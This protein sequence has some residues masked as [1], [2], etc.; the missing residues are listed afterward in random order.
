MPEDML[1]FDDGTRE[2]SFIPSYFEAAPAGVLVVS[3]EPGIK[4][5]A[6]IGEG[7]KLATIKWDDGTQTSMNAPQGAEGTVQATNRRILYERLD[8]PPAQTALT[9]A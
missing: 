5:G 7:T 4:S 9:L 6:L 1:S 2:V 8:R 3:W